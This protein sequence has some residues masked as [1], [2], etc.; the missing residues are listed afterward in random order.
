MR[1]DWRKGF[2]RLFLVY[3]ALVAIAVTL[4]AAKSVRD[5][6]VGDAVILQAYSRPQCAWVFQPPRQRP[7]QPPSRALREE[8]IQWDGEQRALP[9]HC[10]PEV[11]L[12]PI[13]GDPFDTGC[14]AVS[15]LVTK[16]PSFRSEAKYRQHVRSEA[17]AKVP[18]RLGFA[19]AAW[20]LLVGGVAAIGATLGWVVAG[21]FRKP[22]HVD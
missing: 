17:W 19:V 10:V 2:F 3:A 18:M 11:R 13:P 6:F 5:D 12:V 22:T 14:I 7:A 16:D 1:I 9:P 8:C 21:F 20:V 15:K 4:I